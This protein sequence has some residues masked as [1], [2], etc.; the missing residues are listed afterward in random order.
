MDF[1]SCEFVTLKRHMANPEARHAGVRITFARGRV[2]RHFCQ[3][4]RSD[5]AR[6]VRTGWVTELGDGR[7]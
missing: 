1:A 5:V 6:Q 2:N 3:L 7:R 4:L